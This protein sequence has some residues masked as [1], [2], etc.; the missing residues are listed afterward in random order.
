MLGIDN[1]YL[2]HEIHNVEDYHVS[3]QLYT[4]MQKEAEN[5]ESYNSPS[6]SS[7]SSYGINNDSRASAVNRSPE[8]YNLM[9]KGSLSPF[10]AG[11]D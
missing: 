1:P 10:I 8:N 6:N 5:L 2:L 7:G 3:Q 4:R 11:F 9:S